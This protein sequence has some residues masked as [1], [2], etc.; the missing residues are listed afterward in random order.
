[1]PALGDDTAHQ[2]LLNNV[3]TQLTLTE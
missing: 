3:D 2:N 1:L